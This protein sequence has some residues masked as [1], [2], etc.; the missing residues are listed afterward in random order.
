[1]SIRIFKDDVGELAAFSDRE[2]T[3]IR[4]VF[5]WGTRTWTRA[6]DGSW[7]IEPPYTR[8]SLK[9]AVEG[10]AAVLAAAAGEDS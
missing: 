5:E 9:A 2:V 6:Q 7:R 10:K 8:E 4:V 1:M 3:E